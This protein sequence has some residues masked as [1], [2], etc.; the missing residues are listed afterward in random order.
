MNNGFA[1]VLDLI[2]EGN[3]NQTQNIIDS[4]N[5]TVVEVFNALDG[6][7]KVKPAA[8]ESAKKKVEGIS[9]ETIKDRSDRYTK[10]IK[11]MATAIR[12]KK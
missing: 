8:Y 6:D 1:T 7:K 12:K 4:H 3:E 10:K 5:L 11:K 2:A 9:G